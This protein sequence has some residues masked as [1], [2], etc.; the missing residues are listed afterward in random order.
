MRRFVL[1]V[2]CGLMLMGSGVY[3]GDWFEDRRQKQILEDLLQEQRSHN[4]DHEDQQRRDRMRRSLD[5]C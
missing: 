5:P 4:R 1:G 3:A 2:A